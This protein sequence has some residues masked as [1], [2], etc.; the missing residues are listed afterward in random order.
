GSVS[1]A[2]FSAV[3]DRLATL[4][5]KAGGQ[6]VVA[7]PVLP[8]GGTAAVER[9]IT[10]PVGTELDIRLQTPLNSGTAK[11]EQRFEAT[12][13]LD[14]MNGGDVAIPAGSVVRGFVSSVRAAGKIDRQGSLTLSFGEIILVQR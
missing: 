5:V 3:R 13:I 14:V 10:L 1:R 7:Q 8:T 11:V 4:R 6:K 12:T 2:E 9:P